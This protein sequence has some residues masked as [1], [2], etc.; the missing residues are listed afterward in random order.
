MKKLYKDLMLSAFLVVT[1]V[2]VILFYEL[3]HGLII[4]SAGTF[5]LGWC[6]AQVV[7]HY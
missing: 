5:G 2:L 7:D 4:V 1:G 6:F 3:D